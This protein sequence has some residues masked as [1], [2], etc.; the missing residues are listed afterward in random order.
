MGAVDEHPVRSW[1][2]WRAFHAEEPDENYDGDW[3]WFHNLQS[4]PLYRRDLDIVAATSQGEI[5]AFCTISYDDTTRSALGVLEGTAAEHLQRGLGQATLLE[6]MRR[7]KA[8][9]CTRAFITADDPPSD[10]LYASV[11]QTMQTAYTWYKFL[12]DQ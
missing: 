7:L 1:A 11:M 4:A 12:P 9:G 3:S 6:G 5:G 10:A 2:S 8:L